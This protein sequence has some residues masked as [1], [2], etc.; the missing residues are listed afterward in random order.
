MKVLVL[1]AAGRSGRQIVEQGIAKGHEITALIRDQAQSRLFPNQ[2][3]TVTGDALDGN[4]V[5]RAVAGQD[6]VIYALGSK[7]SGETTFFSDTTQLLLRAM[8]AQ[9][10]RRLVCITGVGA[11]ESKGHGGFVYDR[12]IFPLFTRKIYEDKDRQEDLIRSSSLDWIIVRPA[13]FRDGPVKGEL[14]AVTDVR[15]VTLRRIAPQEVAS[16]VLEQLDNDRFLRKAPFIG[17]P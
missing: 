16:F 1:G 4:A 10:V 5:E 7:K 11:G 14:Q 8:Q 3:H 12:L 13:V 17:H 15:S 2:V 9:R 6:A